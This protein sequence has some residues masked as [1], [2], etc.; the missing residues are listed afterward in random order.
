MRDIHEA[1]IV[2]ACQFCNSTTSRDRAPMTMEELIARG[3]EDP[4]A[5]YVAV[6]EELQTILDRKRSIVA[7]KLEATEEAFEREI[8]P[9]LERRR[10]QDP[11]PG[12]L[13][14]LRRG[15]LARRPARRLA[16]ADD[17][18]RSCEGGAARAGRSPPSP[19]PFDAV[20][21]EAVSLPLPGIQDRIS[22]R[23]EE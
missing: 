5:L 9:E 3:P 19:G 2:T 12:G 14:H 15:G 13:L 22:L 4:R 1:N 17:P 7:W 21:A 11:S 23:W 6:V 18:A 16:L 20:A 10:E 8:R